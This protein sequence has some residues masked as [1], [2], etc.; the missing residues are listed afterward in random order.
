MKRP[1]LL[2]SW[3]TRGLG[4]GLIP[5]QVLEQRVGL[6]AL[7]GDPFLSL[8]GHL[9]DQV[10]HVGDGLV[11]G[12]LLPDDLPQLAG[13][14]VPSVKHP[15]ED[16][17]HGEDVVLPAGRLALLDEGVLVQEVDVAHDRPP[18]GGAVHQRHSEVGEFDVPVL[19]DENVVGLQV[20]VDDVHLVHGL[21]GKNQLLDVPQVVCGDHGFAVVR[22]KGLWLHIAGNPLGEGFLAQL[23]NKDEIIAGVGQVCALQ[24]YNIP[25]ASH[26]FLRGHL[27]GCSFDG[28]GTEHRYPLHRQGLPC[29]GVHHL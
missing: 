4:L 1:A 23:I 18:V 5:R 25:P 3:P 6:H 22:H 2:H 26:L 7:D 15:R 11:V 19:C 10:L 16:L 17:A 29:L 24:M 28:K 12:P 20:T 21:E 13:G 27:R 14:G 8:P 9:V